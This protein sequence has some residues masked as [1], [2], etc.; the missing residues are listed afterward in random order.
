M[1]NEMNGGVSKRSLLLLG[2]LAALALNKDTRRALVQGS[3]SAWTDAQATL[4][5][6]VKPTLAQSLAQAH[7][8]SQELAQEAAR[9]GHSAAQLLREE[10]VPRASGLL[11]N[12]LDEV[13]TVA[14][15]LAGTAGELAGTA[16]E[17]AEA[18]AGGLVGGVADTTQTVT[19]QGR[20]Q[21][22]RLLSAAQHTAGETLAGARGARK[23]LLSTVQDRVSSAVHEAAQGAQTHQR[24][25]ERLLKQA[26]RDAERELVAGRKTLSPAKLQKAVDRKVAPL[27][28]ELARELKVL[29]RQTSRARRD[30]RSG[31]SAG[32]LSALVLIGTGVVV[33]ARVPA[34]RQGILKAVEGVSP[35][36]AQSLRMAGRNARNLIGTAWL[37]RIEENKVTPA[38]GAAQSTQAAT[39]GST[40][41]GAVAPDAPA[42][43]RTAAESEKPAGETK[44][45]N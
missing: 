26:R 44:P 7:E 8:R 42:A 29:E 1:R 32:G 23:E 36:A 38:P 18:L 25:M 2:G 35:E 4:E 21:A 39:T 33:L 11:S 13:V 3:R 22:E 30:D 17:R 15:G 27:Q 37:E 6:T 41:A 16:Q 45:T 19:R 28:K 34:A 5:D 10:G 24:R 40:A 9:R 31:G 20:K 43:A 12:V 14:G